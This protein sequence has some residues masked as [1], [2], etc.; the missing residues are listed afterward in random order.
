MTAAVRLTFAQRRGLRGLDVART[1]AVALDVRLAIL[2]A[3]V[4]G[5]HLQAALSRRVG[6]NGL[7][8]QL[9][10]HGADVDDLA[11]A[12][13]DHARNAGLGDDE[14]RVQV[15]VDDLAEIGGAHL[16][17]R[18][19]LDD[20][21]VVD[22]N[23]DDADFLTD[24]GDGL[25]H[26]FL[27]GHVADIAVR[28]DALLFVSG[29][30]LVDQLLIDIVEDDGRARRRIR[31]GD[32]EADAVRRAG[33]EGNLAFQTEILHKFVHGKKPPS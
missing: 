22:Q 27:V 24:L 6:G 32:G 8:A 14:R 31:A 28:L 29:Q 25:L 20:A 4:A 13:F 17:H 21:G 10:H 18:D 12:L 15:N 26:R 33:D 19:A 3:D 2:G 1:D 16:Q 11:V 9:A 5:Q 30:T 7:T 23:I